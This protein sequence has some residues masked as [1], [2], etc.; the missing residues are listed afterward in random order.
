MTANLAL[1]RSDVV[2]IETAASKVKQKANV[3]EMTAGNV[4]PATR[5]GVAAA[6]AVAKVGEAGAA[7]RE[8][9]VR[10]S[11]CSTRTGTDNSRPRKSTMQLP[12]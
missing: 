10:Y 12:Y 5:S 11:G 1:S 6:R 3:T 7:V 4:E 8:A 9:A 2:P